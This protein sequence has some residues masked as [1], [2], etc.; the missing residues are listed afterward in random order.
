MTC[1]L[2]LENSGRSL[3][4]IKVYQLVA[5][6]HLLLNIIKSNNVAVSQSLQ[7]PFSAQ[8]NQLQFFWNPLKLSLLIKEY[9]QNR[10]QD[11]QVARSSRSSASDNEDLID[12][13]SWHKRSIRTSFPSLT[14]IITLFL[15]L[16]V[17][18]TQSHW[19][20]LKFVDFLPPS[21]SSPQHYNHSNTQHHKATLS[22]A[23]SLHKARA[24][25]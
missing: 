24:I 25:C 22:Q 13:L 9:L 23:Q 21:P 14:E 10:L 17:P 15:L 12:R 8:T 2:E 5:Q 3:A 18:S 20:V 16:P 11:Y 1:E 19:P 6:L 7:F 4:N